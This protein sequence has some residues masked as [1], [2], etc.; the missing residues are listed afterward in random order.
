M[1][2]R[3]PPPEWLAPTRRAA[4]DRFRALGYPTMRNED[5]H[6]TSVAPI[7]EANFTPIVG[8]SGQA[9]ASD[10]VP[11]TFGQDDWTQLVFVNG[12]YAESLSSSGALASGARVTTMRSALTDDASPTR[13][14]AERVPHD[15]RLAHG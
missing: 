8:P 4:L 6:F 5:W 11:F 12:W 2:P 3:I 10:L 9:R 7:A 15:N 13:A 14:L 1:P